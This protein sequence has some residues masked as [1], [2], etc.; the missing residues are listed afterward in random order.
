MREKVIRSTKNI[1]IL[2]LFGIVMTACT[3]QQAPLRL[4]TNIWP[5]Y[6]PLYLAREHGLLDDN[7]VRLIGY[8]S[9]S[10]VIRAFRIHSLDAASLTL[11]EALLLLDHGLPIKVILV[12]DVSHGADVIL[13]RDGIEQVSDLRDRTIAVESSALGAYV[14][15]RALQNS[16]ISLDEVKIKHL[17]VNQHELAYQAG[18]IDAAVTFEPYSTRLKEQGAQEIFNSREI[19]G[20]IV[21]VLVVHEDVHNNRL[22][23][24]KHLTQSWFSALEYL[25]MEPDKAA[26][27]MG[28]RLK[29]SNDEVL[30]SYKGLK[31][32]TREQNITM[33]DGE[34]LGLRKLAA[35]MKE[36][37][38]LSRDPK[39]EL[40]LS[41]DALR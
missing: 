31:L 5:G 20:E 3:K 24:L 22:Q 40:V 27:I 35:I 7:R 32:P 11:D 12:H 38:L 17:D 16:N 33:L 4:G 23:D 36:H 41:S 26:T 34:Q 19:P 8:P 6:E 2:L 14:I 25:E 37:Q 29:V 15:T 28:K 1:V 30:A 39:L 18:D 13:A 10:E 21:D 9:A